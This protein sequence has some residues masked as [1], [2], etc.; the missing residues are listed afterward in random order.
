MNTE[1][2]SFK[3]SLK[4]KIINQNK[5]MID[6]IIYI[7]SEKKEN[8]KLIDELNEIQLKST[9]TE[10]DKK[11]YHS[12]RKSLLLKA[13]NNLKLINFNKIPEEKIKLEYAIKNQI[14]ALNNSKIYLNIAPPSIEQHLNN[15]EQLKQV[16]D[17]IDSYSKDYAYF[18]GKKIML[19]KGPQNAGKTYL[20]HYLISKIIKNTDTYQ[21]I[22]SFNMIDIFKE[23]HF[24]NINENYEKLLNDT[25]LFIDDLGQEPFYNNISTEYLS[26]LI[27]QRL[28]NNKYTIISTSRMKNNIENSYGDLI[29]ARLFQEFNTIA[30]NLQ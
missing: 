5:R 3:E 29:S 9:V 20:M 10:E 22:T 13:G 2:L 27:E 30:I 28:A 19:I 16:Y 26:H 15:Y 4:N 8:K 24:N 21:Y 6:N 12:I 18:Q 11:R 14:F 7:E 17:Y 25:F 1:Y 23:I